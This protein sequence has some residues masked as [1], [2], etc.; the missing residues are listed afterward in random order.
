MAMGG[1]L[2]VVCLPDHRWADDGM[3][4]KTDIGPTAGQ[5]TIRQQACQRTCQQRADVGLPAKCRSNSTAGRRICQQQAESAFQ[6]WPD[7]KLPTDS[8]SNAD[9]TRH[10]PDVSCT[11]KPLPT[12]SRSVPSFGPMTAC[13]LGYLFDGAMQTCPSTVQG[14]GDSSLLSA[15]ESCR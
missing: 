3:P 15:I 10:G 2:I 9:Q 8:R 4:T 12:M 7:V 13:W 14:S 6:R 11:S 5:R 1:K